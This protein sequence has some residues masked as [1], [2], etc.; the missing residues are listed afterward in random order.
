M[1][2]EWLVP[3]LQQVGIKDTVVLQFDG[4]PQQDLCRLVD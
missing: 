2:S 4:T 3:Q 1:F